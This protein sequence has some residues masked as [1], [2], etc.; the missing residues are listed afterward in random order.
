MFGPDIYHVLCIV[1]STSLQRGL[2]TVTGFSRLAQPRLNAPY[3][4]A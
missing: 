2:A 1:M 3:L 4:L